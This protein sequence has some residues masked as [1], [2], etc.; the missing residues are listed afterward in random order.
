MKQLWIE[1]IAAYSPQARGRS[2]RAF[3]T[4]QDRLVKELAAA[5]ITDMEQA[6]A[7][8]RNDYLANFNAAFMRPPRAQGCAFVPCP[9]LVVLD[10]ILCE[11]RERTVG[12]DHCVPYPGLTRHRS[13]QTDTAATT[14]RS[15]CW[16]MRTNPCRSITDHGNW[17]AMTTSDNRW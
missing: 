3:Q 12:Q 8:L 14:S 7:Y 6:N 17:H 4:H 2:E 1:M 5:G 13:W 10:D 16:N 9:D 15:R 11:H